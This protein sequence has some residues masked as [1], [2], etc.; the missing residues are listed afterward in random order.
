MT[1]RSSVCCGLHTRTC[2]VYVPERFSDEDS[3]DI[4]IFALSIM[5]PLIRMIDNSTINVRN[6]N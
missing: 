5:A 1:S 6:V 4:P 2:N 3:D